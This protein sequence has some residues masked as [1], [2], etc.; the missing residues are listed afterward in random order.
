MTTVERNLIL[1]DISARLAY[2]VWVKV[3][4]DWFCSEREEYDMEININNFRSLD[5]LESFSNGELELMPYLRPMVT[6]SHSEYD[7]YLRIK[8]HKKPF[9]VIDWLNKKGFDY[10]G[11][12]CMLLARLA[13]DEMY[14]TK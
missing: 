10:R 13:K 12:L 8:T 9:E 14:Q 6:M 11:L 3:H 7:E 2:G 5:V 4:E 1:Q